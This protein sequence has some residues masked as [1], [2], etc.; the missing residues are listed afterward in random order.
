MQKSSHIVP[1]FLAIVIT[2]VSVWS[3]FNPTDRAVWY[4]E[5]MPIF[6]VFALLLLTYQRFQFSGLAYVL[7]SLWMIMHLIGAKY[8]F[9]NVPF[10][11]ANQ[12]LTFLGEDRNH[13]DRVDHY[14]IGFYSYPMAEWLLR[15]RKCGLGVAFFFSLFFI[16]SVAATYEIIEW[17]YAVIEGGNA[18]I[19]FLGSQGDIWD[20]QKDMLADTLGAITALIIYLIARPDLRLRHSSY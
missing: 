19:E 16:M 11:W 14:I 5:V 10:D 8:T 12:Y 13:F 3:G 17:Q 15:K 7:M 18:G 2:V 9:A 1:L 20:A 4:A 6:V